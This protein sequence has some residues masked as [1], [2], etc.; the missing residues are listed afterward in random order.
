MNE[1]DR[2][3]DHLTG[4][5]RPDSVLRQRKTLIAAKLNHNAA[6]RLRNPILTRGD[7]AG[8]EDGPLQAKERLQAPKC[9][10]G[11][12]VQNLVFPGRGVSVPPS[13][14]PI[15][16]GLHTGGTMPT[17]LVLGL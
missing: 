14:F 2:P 9:R 7:W 15:R 4:H 3:L 1:E 8:R 5:A 16:S 13:G 6:L 12:P 11:V 10:V 17:P